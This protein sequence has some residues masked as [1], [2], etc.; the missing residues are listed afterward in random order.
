MSRI[1]Q[2]LLLAGGLA[3]AA[4]MAYTVYFDVGRD[5]P[6][7]GGRVEVAARVA[8][9]YPD[10]TLWREFRQGVQACV[11]KGLA[12]IVEETDAAV[13]VATAR[14]G[15]LVR[16]ELRDVRGVRETKAE[17]QAL[18]AAAPAPVAFV[19]SSNTVLTEAIAEALH[20]A[21]GPDG[22]N[23]PV[24]LVPWASSVLV[25]RP[26][27]GEGP[28]TLLG[29]YP[30]R[31]FRFCPNNQ[32][33]A[34]LLLGCVAAHE[35][36][37]MPRRTVIVVDRHDPYSEDLGAALHR[38]IERLAPETEIVERADSLGLPLPQDPYSL[39]GPAE[40]ALAEWIWKESEALPAGRTTWVLLPLQEDPALRI[41]TALRRHARR[42]PGSGAGPLRVV[43]GDGIGFSN[44]APLAG[45]CPFPVWCSSPAS[46]PAAAQAVG[47]GRS[48]DTQVP[49]EIAA[50]LVVC[51]DV[52]A[53]RPLTSGGLR[54]ALAVLRLAPGDAAAMG[55]SLAFSDSG[56]RTGDDIGH[57]LM[58]RPDSAE[59][60]A[61]AR[62]PS[63]RWGEPRALKRAPLVVRP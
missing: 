57:V 49:A 23:G 59:V 37:Q 31:T 29:I 53:D 6:G 25:D 2:A 22:R 51:L 35:R 47:E 54:D 56:E 45:R 44:L 33:Q 21:A 18:L 38:S 4:L 34:D 60:Y 55:R 14:H 40:E 11:Q 24:L 26:E 28:V 48:P 7:R 58:I 63:G 17:V 1:G 42:L 3:L 20:E 43:C 62:G 9:V 50:A 12:R 61:W 39:P 41:L 10:R 36:D 19:G 30:G 15:R 52:P 13:V 16:F 32:R 8:V 27:P 5:R 46:A